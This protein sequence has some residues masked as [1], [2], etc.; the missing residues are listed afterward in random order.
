MN[1]DGISAWIA[2]V[3]AVGM[4][5]MGLVEAL[6]V[7][8]LPSKLLGIPLGRLARLSLA[9]VGL[10]KVKDQLGAGA[11][12]ALAT[13]Y[14]PD[15]G[16]ILLEGAWRKGPEELAKILRNGLRMAVFAGRADALI[17]S[18]GQDAAAVGTSIKALQAGGAAAMAGATV[19]N[20]AVD[21]E[22]IARLEA[23]IDAR[24]EGAVAAG[25]DK[26]VSS[27]QCVASI[28]AIGGSLWLNAALPAGSKPGFLAALMIGLLAVPVAP[29]AKDLV[30][31]LSS[32]RAS[33][34][35]ARSKP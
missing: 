26:Y 23:A 25:R 16:T 7:L 28:V 1:I 12:D 20:F 8:M 29:I 18:L 14:G 11:I 32:L 35:K 3:A 5:A 34:E 17:A 2:L 6:K 24:V 19:T 27:M 13:V 30:S 31:F 33:F 22:R 21:R 15:A 10:G 4:A 9:T